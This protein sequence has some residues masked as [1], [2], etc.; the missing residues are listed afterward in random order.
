MK[1]TV[2]TLKVNGD[3]VFHILVVILT[4][5]VFSLI[6]N[7]LTRPRCTLPLPIDSW[8]GLQLTLV[9]LNWMKRVNEWIITPYH[10]WLL[11]FDKYC[12]QIRLTNFCFPIENKTW[13]WTWLDD[14]VLI[15]VCDWTKTP[16]NSFFV[17][18]FLSTIL[19][20]LLTKGHSSAAYF[21]PI[22]RWLFFD[23][24]IKFSSQQS[25]SSF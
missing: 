23:K 2:F 10:Y 17:S 19:H 20:N 15:D 16:N 21:I 1:K 13:A 9:T 5:F 25:C 18:F 12:R 4:D 6:N 22:T 3:N 11:Y 7:S 8:D 14:N 24:C